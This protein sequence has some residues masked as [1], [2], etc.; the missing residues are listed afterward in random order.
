[1]APYEELTIRGSSGRPMDIGPDDQ[2]AIDIY[3]DTTVA[4]VTK[5]NI[6]TH[7][8]PLSDELRPEVLDPESSSY[9]EGLPPTLAQ[10]QDQFL[11]YLEPETGGLEFGAPENVESGRVNIF[12]A[13][14]E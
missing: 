12:E 13:I 3:F 5:H 7:R 10:P 1:M 2:L 9:S 6:A 8:F 14:T 4:G 11:T